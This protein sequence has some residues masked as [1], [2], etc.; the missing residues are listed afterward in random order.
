MKRPLL[1]A[2]AFVL[3]ACASST[4]R[5]GFDPQGPAP[6]DSSQPG[7]PPPPGGDFGKDPAPPAPPPEVHEV[8]GHSADTLYKVDPDTNAV[9]VVAKFKDCSAVTDI[10]LDEGSNLYASAND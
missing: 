1:L 2:C 5:D 10:A 7:T 4:S 3:A 9:T 6:T 8:F